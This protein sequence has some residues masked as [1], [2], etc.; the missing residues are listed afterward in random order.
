MVQVLSRTD[1]KMFRKRL[2]LC[3]LMRS[4]QGELWKLVMGEHHPIQHQDP[5]GAATG[6]APVSGT[7]DAFG[8]GLSPVLCS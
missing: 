7:H 1:I 2:C 3:R 4:E 6:L 5:T 8:S